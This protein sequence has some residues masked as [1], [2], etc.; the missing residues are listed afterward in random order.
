GVSLYAEH[1]EKRDAT[2]LADLERK[3]VERSLAEKLLE[4]SG[5]RSARTLVAAAKAAVTAP[6]SVSLVGERV[7][8]L[9]PP[10]DFA[11]G[12][13]RRATSKGLRVR[14]RR[15]SSR[16]SSSR[17]GG[18]P[19]RAKRSPRPRSATRGPRT[20]PRSSA[21]SRPRRTRG[22]TP[23]SRPA[24]TRRARSCGRPSSW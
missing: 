6:G 22:V 7:P 9:A 2:R 14:A 24:S 4:A 15:G 23:L 16:T 17:A 21:C 11:L 19:R 8:G 18:T 12:D 3:R 20:G 13:G 10:I 1:V 5:D